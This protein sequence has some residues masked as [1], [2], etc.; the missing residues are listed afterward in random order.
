[1]IAPAKEV[2]ARVLEL[3]DGFRPGEEVTFEKLLANAAR[4]CST[5][6]QRER[7][8]LAGAALRIHEASKAEARK[9][10]SLIGNSEDGRR[11][12][13]GEST[14]GVN[15]NDRTDRP[16]RTHNEVAKALARPIQ[17]GP[18]SIVPVPDRPGRSR[19]TFDEE[20]DTEACYRVAGILCQYVTYRLV[21]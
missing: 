1:M 18:L 6:P 7:I 12:R 8:Q 3:L 13:S 9:A 16:R 2:D 20:L 11:V 14:V 19:L 17:H 5:A 10:A 21:K 15:D 4:K